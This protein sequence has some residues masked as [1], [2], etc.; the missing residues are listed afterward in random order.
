[1]IDHHSFLII[2]SAVVGLSKA[3]DTRIGNVFQKGISGGQKRR[4]SMGVEL[5]TLPK[6]VQRSALP[7]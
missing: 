1:M 3:Q 2:V 6:L 7:V 5:L 4:V